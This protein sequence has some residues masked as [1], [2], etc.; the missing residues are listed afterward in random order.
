MRLSDLLAKIKADTSLRTG[1]QFTQGCAEIVNL[2]ERLQFLDASKYGGLGMGESKIGDGKERRAGS[3]DGDSVEDNADVRPVKNPF[4]LEVSS[5]KVHVID[6]LDDGA[7]VKGC[8]N[9]ASTTTHASASPQCTVLLARINELTELEFCASLPELRFLDVSHNY[10]TSIDGIA[11][12]AQ[13]RYADCSGNLLRRIDFSKAAPASI[14][15]LNL[16][17]WLVFSQVMAL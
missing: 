4:A 5:S 8:F 11:H 2:L 14:R 16:G 10:L 3:T 1:Q 6:K 12:S 7:F 17:T 9:A 13:L 15:V